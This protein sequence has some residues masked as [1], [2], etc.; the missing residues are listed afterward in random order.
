MPKYF[1]HLLGDVRAH[2]LIGHDCSGD[3]EARQYGELLAHNVG[4]D[5]PDLVRECNH[6]SVVDESDRELFKIPLASLSA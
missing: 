5:R 2:D 3:K 4:T 6:I 1:F